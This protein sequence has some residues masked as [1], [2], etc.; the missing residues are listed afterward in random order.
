MY[1]FQVTGKGDFPFVMLSISKAYPVDAHHAHKIALAC[2]TVAPEQNIW[3]E[4]KFLPNANL[5][6][7]Q[8]WPIT[9]MT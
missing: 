5:W 4:S 3:L 2:P 8:K 6:R 9:S 1:R 7:N